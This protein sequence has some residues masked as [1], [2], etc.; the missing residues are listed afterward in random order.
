MNSKKD[1]D[2]SLSVAKI[3][4]L[5]NTLSESLWNDNVHGYDWIFEEIEV[6]IKE[7][8]E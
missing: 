6:L 2:K 8:A 3:R 4:E 1:T 7:V 5:L